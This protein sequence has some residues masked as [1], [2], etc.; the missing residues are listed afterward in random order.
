MSLSRRALSVAAMLLATA[1]ITSSAFAATVTKLNDDA[2]APLR[3][4]VV[5]KKIR[6]DK[7]PLYD[8]K[9]SLIDL[10]EF[11][12]WA[13]EGKVFIHDGKGNLEKV[14][15]PAMRYFRGQVNGDPESFA[16]FSVELRTGKITGMVATR[17]DNFAID[18]IPRKI[19]PHPRNRTIDDGTATQA[20]D[21]MLT[22]T[23]AADMN[24]PEAKSWQCAVEEHYMNPVGL[25]RTQTDANGMPIQSQAITGTQHYA[26]K[27]EIETDDELYTNSGNS[28][29]ALTTY[30]TNLTGAVSTI[31]NRDLLT[32]VVL[33]G[34]HVHI[35]GPGTDQW[36]QAADTSLALYEFGTYY[37]N[38]PGYQI[39]PHSSAVFL[40]GKNLSGGIA[41]E[42]VICSADFFCGATGATCGDV[43][44]ANKYG[45]AYAWCGLIGNG[46]FGS[47]PDPNATTNG[48]LYGMPTTTQNYW[49]LAE[50]AH[51][52][53]HN[54]AGHHTHC[55]AISD[56]ERIASGF[57]DGSP[58]NS[59]SNFVDH[60]YASEGAG[61][62][63]G[64]N[65]VF[66]SQ[67]TFRGTIMSY[68]HNVFPVA[69]PFVPQ[70]RFTFGQATEPSIHELNDYMLRALGG[71]AGGVNVVTNTLATQSSLTA[72]ASVTANS[73][74]NAAS[75]AG[76]NISTY[77]WSITNGTITSATNIASITFTAGAS[78]TTILK[79]TVYGANN[80]GVTDTKSVTINT[81]TYNPP[82]GVEAHVTGSTSAQVNWVAPVGGTAPG[83]YNV[84]RSQDGTTY[85]FAGFTTPPTVTFTDAVSTNKA[86]LYKVRT[87]DV[88]NTTESADSN[89]DLA[90]IVVYTNATLTDGT[91]VIQAVD[92]N[93]LRTAVE[94]V[95]IL[96]GIGA[97]SYTYLP[98]VGGTTV[99]HA[100]DINELRTNLNTAITGLGFGSPV[101]TNG[102]ITAGS[103]VVQGKD[104]RELRTAMR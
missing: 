103:S 43:N 75:V 79:A 80:C 74:G 64:T 57:T 92:I 17:D 60:C 85:S 27:L 16:Y 7:L 5:S 49:P 2:L 25:R 104:F 21:Y 99:V 71:L 61:C 98:A 14:D 91:S 6:L 37:H 86:Y 46:G 76:T 10:E 11:Q 87:A 3:A 42:A 44:S 53:G 32:D 12:V 36:T 70:S 23:N 81:A 90:T 22:S 59:T 82:T 48:A 20:Y 77:S 13:P 1:A 78:G 93:E 39:G 33:V 101:Y 65:Y 50:Y 30:V 95:R 29:S 47:I 102:T 26:I 63:S 88:G 96:K 97:G 89:R 9:R 83:R 38:N 73:T 84:Y 35:G 45:G 66:G 28:S 18:A 8:A 55:V 68:C 31:Y 100:A 58:A 40:S 56:A 15:P 52:L 72:P 34:I 41:W 51:E 24:M 4:S 69:P 19:E 54:L 94:A 67:T 62:F